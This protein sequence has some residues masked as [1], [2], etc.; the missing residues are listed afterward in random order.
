MVIG[1]LSGARIEPH[2]RYNMKTQRRERH[3]HLVFKMKT[4]FAHLKIQKALADK[5]VH[6]HF[7]FNLSGYVQHLRYCMVP[8]A[9]KLQ[10]DLDLAPWSFPVVQF[11][12]LL[13]LAK[14]NTPQLDARNGLASGKGRKRAYLTFSELTDVFVENDIKVEQD[15]LRL[16]K[17]R[18][19]AGDDTL[20]NTLE[21]H[22]VAQLVAKVWK[23]WH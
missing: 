13:E 10:A 18:K 7:S 12:A 6:G 15:A 14:S 20:Y 1:R 19:V 21:K 5:G 2:K 11:E 3:K 9:K 22:D 17:S 4:T 16:A 8:S 23:H